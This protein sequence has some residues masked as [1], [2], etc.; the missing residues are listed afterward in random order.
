MKE[1]TSWLG[2]KFKVSHDD[3]GVLEKGELTLL[4][5]HKKLFEKM[6][7]PFA[8]RMLSAL[9]YWS[10]KGEFDFPEAGSLNQLFPDVETLKMQDVL[11]I[12][13]G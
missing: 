10:T 9:E 13:Y 5:G 8:K 11:T 12:N 4:P 1:L 2:V 3:P 7:E 6:P